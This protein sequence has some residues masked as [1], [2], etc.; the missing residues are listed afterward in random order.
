[1]A[2]SGYIFLGHSISKVYIAPRSPVN[3]GP[4]SVDRRRNSGGAIVA[5][6]F[7]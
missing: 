6:V 4:A 3:F 1:M 5:E 2:S 7:P